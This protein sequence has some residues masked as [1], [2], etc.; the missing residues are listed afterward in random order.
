VEFAI[1]F[2]ADLYTRT[3]VGDIMDIKMTSEKQV[4]HDGFF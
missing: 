4:E 1:G 3:F 2:D